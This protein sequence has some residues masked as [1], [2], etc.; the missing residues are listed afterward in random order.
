MSNLSCEVIPTRR[1]N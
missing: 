1:H